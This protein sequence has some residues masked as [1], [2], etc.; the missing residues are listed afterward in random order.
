MV[1]ASHT[2]AHLM[3]INSD[4]PYLQIQKFWGKDQHFIHSPDCHAFI[5]VRCWKKR[6]IH[7]S[8]LGASLCTVN[9]SDV[10]SPEKK[11]EEP[12]GRDALY[13]KHKPEVSPT[14][15]HFPFGMRL[16]M[17]H[18]EIKKI[19]FLFTPS[20]RSKHFYAVLMD[21]LVWVEKKNFLEN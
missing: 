10:Q 6:N 19:F 21:R 11:P 4:K 9:A 2:F 1:L 17:Y 16:R 15:S 8:Q 3:L 12:H 7:V 5:Q 13:S 18:T 14:S 20:Q